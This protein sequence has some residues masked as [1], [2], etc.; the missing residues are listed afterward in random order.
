[1]SSSWWASLFT[2]SSLA[3]TN[4]KEKSNFKS[5]CNLLR[6]G[7]WRQNLGGALFCEQQQCVVYVYL[8]KGILCATNNN[9]PFQKHEQQVW[10]VQK[11]QTALL[12][13]VPLD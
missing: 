6:S 13:S 8:C 12:T 10:G 1:M 11:S 9:F 7:R 5:V 3:T 2:L 4:Y